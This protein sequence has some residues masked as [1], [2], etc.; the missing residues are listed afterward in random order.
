MYYIGIDIAKF[1][2]AIF[3]QTENGEIINKGEYFDNTTSGFKSLLTILNNLD[4]SQQKKIGLEATGHYHMNLIAFLH[5]HNYDVCEIN[6]YFISQYRKTFSNRKNKNDFIDS[7][8]ISS[9]LMNHECKSYPKGFYHIYALK[10]LT[11]QRESLIK[12]RSRQLIELTNILDIIFPEFKP[13]FNKKLSGTALY[14]LNKYKTPTH[15]ANMTIDSY[16]NMKKDL[17]KVM[18]YS[19]FL[20][21]KQLAKNTVGFFDDIHIIMLEASL[22]L[23]FTLNEQI[24]N[25]ENLIRKEVL[26]LKPKMLGIKW[27][28]IF[29]IA[30][31]IAE[32]NFFEG[33]NSPS[34]CLA[35]AGLEPGRYQSGQ[36]DKNLPMVKHGSGHLRN[37]L[38]YGSFTLLGRYPV[39]YDYYKKKRDEG[40]SHN[41]ALSHVAKKLLRVIFYLEKNNKNFNINLL[42]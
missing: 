33:F 6:P 39:L 29:Y 25:I 35:F 13:F 16:N 31:I 5:N 34:K 4:L 20:E 42:K 10:S 7:E 23:Y 21:L 18:K 14:I 12:A 3:I 32:Y 9:Y 40:K 37:A 8:I 15:I 26:E 24:K 41:V 36:I 17:R 19:R 38:I 11:R 1:K 30:T 27:F 22:T 2:H 28:S